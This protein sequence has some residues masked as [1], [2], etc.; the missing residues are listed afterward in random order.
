V[1]SLLQGD[2][3]SGNNCGFDEYVDVPSIMILNTL[4]D[5]ILQSTF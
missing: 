2:V 5:E 1:E 4:L 3:G